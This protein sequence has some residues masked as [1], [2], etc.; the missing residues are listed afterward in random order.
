MLQ[1]GCVPYGAISSRPD[2]SP[3][4]SNV[5]PYRSRQDLVIQEFHI[6]FFRYGWVNQYINLA[7]GFE[8]H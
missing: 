5:G 2:E 3:L 6:D 7:F 4:C 8:Q 1:V